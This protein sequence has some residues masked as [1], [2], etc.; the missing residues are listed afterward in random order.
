MSLA[1]RREEW[2]S[3]RLSGAF[4]GRFGEALLRGRHSINFLKG[5]A[6]YEPGRNDRL[7][8]FIRSGVVSIGTVGGDGREIIYDLRKQG[9]I[10]GELCALPVSRRDRAVALEETLATPIAY[11]EILDALHQNR[12]A[13]EELLAAF[14]GSLASAYEQTERLSTRD[15]ACR[16]ARTLQKLAVQLGRDSGD[17]VEIRTYL[18]QEELSRMAGSSRERVS[19]VLNALR[20]AG[21]IAYSRRGHL[22]LHRRALELTR[23]ENF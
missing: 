13:L 20:A 7:L 17:F 19:S 2:V 14:A 21:F 11:T 18:T 4:R 15:V 8:F 12:A 9:D 16:V 10:A 22:L 3:V 1:Q 5:E 6:L 23:V